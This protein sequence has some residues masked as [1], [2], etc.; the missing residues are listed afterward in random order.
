M[1]NFGYVVVS[2]SA[3]NLAKNFDMEK[4]MGFFQL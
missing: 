1:N 2:A 4:F 3:Q